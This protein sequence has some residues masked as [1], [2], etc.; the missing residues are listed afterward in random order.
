M[1]ILP[2]SDIRYENCGREL[3]FATVSGQIIAGVVGYFMNVM[4]NHDIDINMKGF[5]PSGA[6]IK[7]IYAGIRFK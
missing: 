6:V 3:L 7:S 1:D 2:R 4:K 5:K